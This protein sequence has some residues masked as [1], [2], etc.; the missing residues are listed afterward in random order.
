MVD[1]RFQG[2][3]KGVGQT[4]ILGRVHIANLQVTDDIVLPCSLL[5]LADEK[6]DFLFGL[7]N[8][9]RH[10]CCIDL[11]DNLLRIKSKGIS[12]PFM[13]EAQI[14]RWKEPLSESDVQEL[15]Q[16]GFPRRSVVKAL[17]ACD[18]DKGDA[19]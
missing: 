11:D 6:V 8:L 4:S 15:H 17:E 7:D 3:A 10:R 1:T 2:I 19:L 12:I 9:R 5:V 16:M 14:K 18:G 13:N